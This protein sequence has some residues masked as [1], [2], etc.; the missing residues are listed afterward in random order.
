MNCVLFCTVFCV[1]VR[2]TVSILTAGCKQCLCLSFKCALLH[3]YLHP[4][5]LRYICT[6]VQHPEKFSLQWIYRE[7]LKLWAGDMMFSAAPPWGQTVQTHISTTLFVSTVAVENSAACRG[8]C[9]LC[10]ARLRSGIFHQFSIIHR[11]PPSSPLCCHGAA[12][13]AWLIWSLQSQS[14]R[15]T[16]TTHRQHRSI[17]PELTLQLKKSWQSRTPSPGPPSDPNISIDL[18]FIQC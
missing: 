2:P 17:R 6:P 1:L 11:N 8:R 5:V 15:L 10:A 16:A 9:A 3:L 18:S 14:C 7:K 4:T 12:A 13:A